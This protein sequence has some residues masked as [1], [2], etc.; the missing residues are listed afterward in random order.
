[1]T[2]SNP[3]YLTGGDSP[4]ERVIAYPQSGVPGRDGKD[5]KQGPQGPRGPAGPA[6]SGPALFT[7]QGAPPD[8]VEGARP[9]DGWLDT[10][11]GDT[12]RLD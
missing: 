1:M 11:T 7:G 12:Y 2:T 5:G 4:Y 3:V 6:S 9:G 8:Y 10:L